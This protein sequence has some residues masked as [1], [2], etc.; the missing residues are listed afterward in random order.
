MPRKTPPAESRTPTK[1]E[2]DA[3]KV[4]MGL[5]FPMA[6]PDDPIF[7]AG[8]V[9]GMRRAPPKPPKKP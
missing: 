5:R 1:T 4:R 6:S 8:F 7:K 3:G 9:I 2:P